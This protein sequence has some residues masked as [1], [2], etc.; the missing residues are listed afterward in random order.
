MARK[1]TAD[2]LAE[3]IHELA[4]GERERTVK[5]IVI[6]LQEFMKAGMTGEDDDTWESGFKAAIEVITANYC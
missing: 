4:A 5:D 3:A 2:D 6:D 1:L